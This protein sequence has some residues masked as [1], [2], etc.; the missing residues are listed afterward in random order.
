MTDIYGWV[1][2]VLIVVAYTLNVT[3]RVQA[4]GTWWPTFWVLSA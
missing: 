3:G 1:G 2:M 4:T